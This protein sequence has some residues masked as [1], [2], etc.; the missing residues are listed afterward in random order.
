MNWRRLDHLVLRLPNSQKVL[1]RCFRIP[2]E[3][4]YGGPVDFSVGGEVPQ[5]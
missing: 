3:S 2:P 4:G 5:H 1:V